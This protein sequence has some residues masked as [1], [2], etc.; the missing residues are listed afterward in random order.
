MSDEVENK[1]EETKTDEEVKKTEETVDQVKNDLKEDISLEHLKALE[2]R[3]NARI[4][5]IASDKA[6]DE[7]EKEE[8]RAQVKK[9]QE[10]IEHLISAQEEREKKVDNT[11]T[12]VVPPSDLDPPTHKNPMPEDAKP[13][14][15]STEGR[16][17]K[18][19]LRW[20]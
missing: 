6:M 10:R 16:S 17:N 1:P 12:I 3:L 13:E 19:R 2:D 4:R 14:N 11:T 9:L 15:E 8:L 20:W 7:E 5:S 18:K